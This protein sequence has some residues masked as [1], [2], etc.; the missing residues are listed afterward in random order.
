MEDYLGNNDWIA[1]GPWELA[2]G[3]DRVPFPVSLRTEGLIPPFPDCPDH[4]HNPQ[5]LTGSTGQVLLP[6]DGKLGLK[7]AILGHV[8]KRSPGFPRDLSQSLL[9]VTIS[10]QSLI[11]VLIL[12]DKGGG[13]I[14]ES[15][16]SKAGKVL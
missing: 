9:P 6:S 1:N 12:M 2:V 3:A 15:W 4:P 7:K 5:A 10:S 13:R 11:Q 16:I 8:A 14:M